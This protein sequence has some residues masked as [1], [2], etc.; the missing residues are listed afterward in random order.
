MGIRENTRVDRSRI[1]IG[2]LSD[3]DPAIA[4]WHSKTP[5]ERLEAAELIRQVLYGYDATTARLQRPLAVSKRAR[6]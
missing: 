5:V 2:K 6:R 3:P 1:W 4:Y